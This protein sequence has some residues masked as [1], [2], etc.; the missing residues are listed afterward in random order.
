M[1]G[2][3]SRTY[4]KDLISADEI[5]EDIFTPEKFAFLAENCV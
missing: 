1:C 3:V 2:A 5:L 4:A